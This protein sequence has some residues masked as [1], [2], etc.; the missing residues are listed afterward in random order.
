MKVLIISHNPL[1]TYQNMGKTMLSLFHNFG[2]SELCQLYIY[3]SL[4][5]V[6]ACSSFYRITD[7]DVV[8]SYF[9][10]Q[11]KGKEVTPDLQK[12]SVFEDPQDEKVYRN[13]KNSSPFRMIARD[14]IWQFARWYNR[15]LRNWLDRENPDSIFVAPGTAKFVYKMAVKIAQKR[16]IPIVTYICDDYYFVKESKTLLGMFQQ[17]MLKKSIK[18]L[19]EKTAKLITICDELKEC[20][21]KEFNLPAATIMTGTNFPIAEKAMLREVPTSI[22]YMGNISCNRYLSLAAMG[23]ALDELNA[24]NGT[25]Y[26]LKIYS[27]EKDRRI[28]SHFDGIASVAFCGFV[29]GAEFNRIFHSADFLLHTEAFDD[30]SI[31]RVKHSVS[32]K[33][34]DSLGSGIPLIAYGPEEVSSM[35]HLIRND[36]AFGI[37]EPLKLK[38]VLH[39]IFTESDRR[40]TVVENAL[41]VARKCHSSAISSK[42]LYDIFQDITWKSVLN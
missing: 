14:L 7:K 36:C 15:D 41:C 42:Y 21:T 18:R 9:K 2:K 34:A 17:R 28:L 11:V 25:C 23:R 31:D 35:K 8:K 40:K 13:R 30:K 22:T 32:T 16:N 37:T 12:H 20:Y 19:M 1:S 26:S 29:G 39:K 33:I 10:F 5:D 27:G 38:V 6:D 4:P 24:E 3:P